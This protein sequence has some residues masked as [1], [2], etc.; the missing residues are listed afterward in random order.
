MQNRVVPRQM[1]RPCDEDDG[2][3]KS[4]NASRLQDKSPRLFNGTPDGPLMQRAP[5]FCGTLATQDAPMVVGA[6][7][8]SRTSCCRG[9]SPPSTRVASGI[10]ARQGIAHYITK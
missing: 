2:S 3:A 5:F 9:T 1:A 8:M 6:Y 7:P 10:S 4:R